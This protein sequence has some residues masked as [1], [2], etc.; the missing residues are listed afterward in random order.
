MGTLLVMLQPII[1]ATRH[2]VEFVV[3]RASEF[4]AEARDATPARDFVGALDG[5]RLAV[6][7]EIKRRSPSAGVLSAALDPAE[8]AARYQKG[9]AS[10]ISV[11]TEPEFFDGS[12]DDLRA[13]GQRV[14]LPVLRKDFVLDPAQIWESRAAGAD[15]VLLIIAAVGEDAAQLISVAEEAGITPLVEVHDEAEAEI[16]LG[17]GAAVIGVNNR[18]LATF[19]TDLAVAERLAPLV[20]S[21]RARIAES[22]IVDEVDAQRMAAAG[23]DG[24]LVGEA[25]V[26]ADDPAALIGLL[27]GSSIRERR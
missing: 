18:D 4:E 19:T 15:A 7:A 22:G 24:V 6:I 16:A 2:R 3:D 10:A 27:R 11:L 8:Q 14:D 23:Y 13:V 17:A 20:A 9:G 5:A 1:E 21:A 26:R 12:L 25:A